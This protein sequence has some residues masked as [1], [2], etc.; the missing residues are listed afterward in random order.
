MTIEDWLKK[1]VDCWKG[2]EIDSVLELFDENVEYW[3]TPF[4][5]LDGSKE[6]KSEWSAILSQENIQVNTDVL[7]QDKNGFYIVRWDLSYDNEV[8]KQE[9]SGVYLIELNELSKCNYF[10][11]VGEKNGD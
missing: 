9:W 11:Q 5:R 3:E 7:G 10:L 8:G 6:L 2:H 4:K 1:F